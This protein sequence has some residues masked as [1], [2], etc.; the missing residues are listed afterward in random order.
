MNDLPALTPVLFLTDDTLPTCEPTLIPPTVVPT[1]QPTGRPSS[2]LSTMIPTTS[3]PT[4]LPSFQSTTS[5]PTGRPTTTCVPTF[6]AEV[7]RSDSQVSVVANSPTY[8]ILFSVF[9]SL[10]LLVSTFWCA[11]CY[12]L[13]ISEKKP[14]RPHKIP[15]FVFVLQNSKQQEDVLASPQFQEESKIIIDRFIQ[16]QGPNCLD[17]P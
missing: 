14:S 8:I 17:Q 12:F 13:S 3:Q 6:I 9:F 5:Q 4:G 10:C 16:E 11:H 1:N 15:F 7:P 2:N